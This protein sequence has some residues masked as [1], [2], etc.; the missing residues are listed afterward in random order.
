MHLITVCE[1]SLLLQIGNQSSRALKKNPISIDLWKTD[2]ILVKN[3]GVDM[4]LF[5]VDE[6]LKI[7][8]KVIKNY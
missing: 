8:G 4:N 7:L 1:I 3:F 2:I 5:L 6:L